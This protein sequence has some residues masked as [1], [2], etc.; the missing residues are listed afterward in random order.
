MTLT[1]RVL[2]RVIDLARRTPYFHL[3]H[4]DGTIYM[5]RYWVVPSRDPGSASKEG[6]FVAGWRQRPIIW[7][8]QRFGVAIRL[9][10]IHSPDLDREMHD[11]PWTFASVVLRGW[12]AEA[13]PQHP[14]R[15]EFAVHAELLDGDAGKEIPIFTY[16]AAREAIH[17]PSRP[18]ASLTKR[19]PAV[20]RLRNRGSFALRR[21]YERHRITAVS[22]GGVWTLFVTFRKRQAWGFFTPRGK[23]WWWEFDS[24]HNNRPIA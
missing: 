20:E 8:L 19:E 9:H 7:L 18:G 17:G 2:D 23:I 5:E 4:A 22:P 6:C 3:Y 13:R 1:E 11:H 14:E 24:V 15:A 10:C 12:Y 16:E 21:F